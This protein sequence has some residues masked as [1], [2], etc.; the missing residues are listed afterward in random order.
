MSWI[1]VAYECNNC[2]GQFEDLV[3]RSKRDEGSTCK[4]CELPVSKE[5]ELIEAP[6]VLRASWPDGRRTDTARDLI[7]ASRLEA[8]SYNL[9][10]S[11]RKGHAKEVAKLRT[12][13]PLRGTSKDKSTKMKGD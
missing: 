1:S 12:P 8:E 4:Y 10:P 11:K 7:E 2:R 5:N 3:K 13:A 9:P 6:K